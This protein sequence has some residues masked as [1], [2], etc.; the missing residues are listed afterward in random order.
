MSGQAFSG[1]AERRRA[2]PWDLGHPFGLMPSYWAKPVNGGQAS[3]LARHQLF[4]CRGC[5]PAYPSRVHARGSRSSGTKASGSRAGRVLGFQSEGYGMPSL[6][7][8][9]LKLSYCLLQSLGK[10]R[11]PASL[12]PAGTDAKCVPMASLTSPTPRSSL[13]KWRHI[14]PPGT[15]EPGKVPNSFTGER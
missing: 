6:C 9:P 3:R 8:S 5:F 14:S 13:W 7:F 2:S 15:G 12:L 10:G 11:V 4:V 1:D